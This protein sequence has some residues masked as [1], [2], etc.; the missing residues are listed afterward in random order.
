MNCR[1]SEGKFDEKQDR[2]IFK[3][4]LHMRNSTIKIVTS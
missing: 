2:W 3:K 1:I 4:Y